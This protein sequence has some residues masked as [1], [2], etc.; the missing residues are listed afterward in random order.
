MQGPSPT[1]NPHL[2]SVSHTP[3][4]QTVPP[5]A[6]VH[7]PS[8]LRSP[9]LLSAG[10]Q[11]PLT[12]TTAP[13][14]AVQTPFSVGLWPGSLGIAV[15]FGSFGVHVL[16]DSSH[17]S[18]AGHWESSVQPTCVLTCGPRSGGTPVPCCTW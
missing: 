7:G 8:P 14:A 1:A 10:S 4:R 6:T 13:A 15:P 16:T 12:Q 11:T 2:L 9:H 17:Q 18:A 3:E 5:F